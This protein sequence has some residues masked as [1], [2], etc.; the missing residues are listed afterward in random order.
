MFDHMEIV[1]LCKISFYSVCVIPSL[2]AKDNNEYMDNM[3]AAVFLSLTLIS[4]RD[5]L[6]LIGN[7][8]I[9]SSPGKF[10]PYL[11]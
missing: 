4:F 9:Q 7:E 8:L 5:K 1:G 2:K 11:E 3:C 6:N 10:Q